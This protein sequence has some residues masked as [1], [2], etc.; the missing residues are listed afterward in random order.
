MKVIYIRDSKS[1]GYVRIG[2][3]EGEKKLDFT[4]SEEEYRSLGS[5][6]IGDEVSD[7]SLLSEYDMRYKAKMYALRI[8]AYA[9]NNELSLVRKLIAKS[10][11]TDIA[12]ETAREMVGLGYV[13]ERR[14]LER[15]I[16][17]EVANKL[18]GRKKLIPKLLS[19]GYRKAEIEEV[20]SD[21]ISHGVVDF[22]KSKAKLIEKML[23][24]N[25]DSEQI[26]KLLYKFG[27]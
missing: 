18:T 10:I 14:Q 23:P 25:A 20:I 27:Y 12:K 9:D 19:K 3:S 4:V 2:I 7:V 22:E 15:I 1:K 21:L 8:L 11:S 5:L 26:R 24:E 17:S 13:N 6:R 16:E